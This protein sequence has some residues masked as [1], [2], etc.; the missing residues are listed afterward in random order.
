[1]QYNV[2]AAIFSHGTIFCARRLVGA[3]CA[4][5]FPRLPFLPHTVPHWTRRRQTQ[6]HGLCRA[7]PCAFCTS[8]VFWWNVSVEKKFGLLLWCTDLH[9]WCAAPSISLAPPLILL[10]PQ[11]FSLAPPSFS[12]VQL[13][14]VLVP[15][16]MAAVNFGNLFTVKLFVKIYRKVTSN[17]KFKKYEIVNK[18]SINSLCMFITFQT[19][20]NKLISI[21]ILN[22]PCRSL[23]IRVKRE[24]LIFLN[25]LL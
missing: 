12:L 3:V 15:Q 19:V 8:S 1:M 18:R 17:I 7:T 14:F 20:I 25:P 22:R 23:W 9:L 2:P 11:S 13:S 21:I 4:A 5:C 16:Q 10:A 24:G 6:Q